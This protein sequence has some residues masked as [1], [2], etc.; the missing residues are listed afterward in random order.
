MVS[1]QNRHIGL[2]AGKADRLN[3]VYDDGADTCDLST[4]ALIQHCNTGYDAGWKVTCAI[5]VAKFGTAEEH[6]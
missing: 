5:G 3:V 1:Q 6:C 2:S 4:L